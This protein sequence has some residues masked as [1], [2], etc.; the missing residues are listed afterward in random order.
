[1]AGYVLDT[2]A[3]IAYLYDEEGSDQA[4]ALIFGDDAVAVPFAA[5]ME[6]EYKLLRELPAETSATMAAFLDWP[7][8]VVE[9]DADWRHQAAVIKSRRR[10]S[11]ADAWVASLALLRDAELVHKDPE[12]DSISEL[13]AVRL[14]YRTRGRQ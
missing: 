10:L 12:F 1:V 14:P 9:S 3:I 5:V 6:V 13:R 8:Q 4:E 7:V 2:S 11:Y